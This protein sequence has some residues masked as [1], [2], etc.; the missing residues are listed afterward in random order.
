M[1]LTRQQL[2]TH[3][4]TSKDDSRPVLE[5][6]YVF[7]DGDDTV[8]VST[9][10]YVLSEVRQKNPALDEFPNPVSEREYQEVESAMIQG[11]VAKKVV[12]ALPK[13]PLLPILT[14]ALVQKDEV[15]TT[16]LDRTISFAYHPQEG[17]FPDYQKL[18]PAPAEKQITF[19]PD[20]MRQA[21]ELF[22]GDTMSVTI[23]FGEAKLDPIVLRGSRNGAKIT[24]IV[25]PLKG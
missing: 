5:H 11:V 21:L 6:I 18:I 23:E 17:K 19:N 25:M 14:H 16:D 7:Q 2:L 20:K 15:I 4:T 10:S 8:A 3:H 12:A 24:V 9:D 1:L 22:R 13:S